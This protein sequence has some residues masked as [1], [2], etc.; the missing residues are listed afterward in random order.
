MKLHP[1]PGGAVARP[2]VDPPQHLDMDLYLRVAPGTLLRKRLL[3]EEG[4]L[5]GLRN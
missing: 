5:K 2:F 1:I 4:G 3:V